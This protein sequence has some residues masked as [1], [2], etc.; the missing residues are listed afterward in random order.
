MRPLAI[1]LEHRQPAAAQQTVHQ[2]SD[3]D[4]L[5]RARQ[6]GD[7]EPDGRVEQ[8][9]PSRPARVPS[10]ALFDDVGKAGGHAGA[11]N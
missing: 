5:A 10:G 6:A 7:A 3:E 4:R 1:G 11:D 2:R 8:L 9:S